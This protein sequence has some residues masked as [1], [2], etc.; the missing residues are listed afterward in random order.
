VIRSADWETQAL[1]T[2]L[3]ATIALVGT[4]A[5]ALITSR[6]AWRNQDQ[7]IRDHAALLKDMKATEDMPSEIA[8][9]LQ[10]LLRWEIRE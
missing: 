2:I 4:V 3:P 10:K 9:D 8:A 5:A 6:N 7:R 1:L